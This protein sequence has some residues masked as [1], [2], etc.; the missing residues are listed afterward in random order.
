MDAPGKVPDSINCHSCGAI[1]DL[2]GQTGFTHVECRH[3]GALSVVPLQF[4]DFLL[5]NPIGIGGMGTVYKAI[6]LPLNRYLALKIVRKN[7]STN[8]AFISSFSQEAQA[9]ASVNHPNVAQVY[10]FGEIDNQYYLSMELCQR[11]S[12]DDRITKLGRLPEPEVLS[13]GRQIASALLCA[14]QGGLLHR[15]V[16]PGNILFNED[17]VPKIVDFGLARGHGRDAED[18]KGHAPDQIWGTPYYI[19]PEKLRGQPEDLRSDIYS[20]G[21]TLF[22][23]L[24]GRPP[25]EADTAGEVV[26]K[27]ATQPALS[28]KTYAPD[29][30]ERTTQVIARMLAKDP[31]ERYETYDELIEDLTGALDELKAT[32]AVKAIVAPTGER[33]SILSLVGTLAT[34]V[35]C[36]AAVWFV[37][38]KRVTIF[39]LQQSPA[40]AEVVNTAPAPAPPAGTSSEE[41]NFA[42]D[43]PWVKAWNTATLQLAQGRYTDALL[44]YDSALQVAGRGQFRQRQWIQFFQGLTLLAADRPGEASRVLARARDIM[45]KPRIPEEITTGNFANVL[46]DTMVGSLPLADVE[47]AIPRLPP[48]AVALTRFTAGFKYLEKSEFEKAATSFREYRKL[49][50][51]AGQQWAFNLQALADKLARQCDQAAGTMADIDTLA[52]SGKYDDALTRLNVAATNAT[53]SALKLALL[54]KQPDLERAAAQDREKGQ[55]ERQEAETK[56]HEQEEQYRQRDEEDTRVISAVEPIV[57]PFWE[58][59]DFKDAL[60]QYEACSSKVSTVAG[61]KLLDPRIDRARRLWEFKQQLVADFKPHPYD[62]ADLRTRTGAPLPG[63]VLRATDQQLICATPYGEIA[64]DWRDFAP[65]ALIQLAD[66]YVAATAATETPAAHALRFLRLAIFCKQYG[67][68]RIAG[69]YARQA[70]QLQPSLQGEVDSILGP[71]PSPAKNE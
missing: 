41:V 2:T 53:L 36:V 5:L 43:T 52:K 60:A 8:P 32:Q 64:S 1:L 15:D 40:P 10:A 55:Q 42:E 19:A 37:W 66:F 33:F 70:V 63:K 50:R 45:V 34:L 46:I 56:R 16:K 68:D 47:A 71:T 59:Y 30:N 23:A 17:G 51:T 69:D 44:G 4:G 11:G 25:F 22:H 7:L 21:A 35:V 12:L 13:I 9:A 67:Q 31:A 3:C 54:A 27:H 39:Q 49:D 65:A 24:A 58:N 28:L 6:D 57:A 38:E 20:L 18:A 26:T 14:W 61:H 62:G 48:W 29:L